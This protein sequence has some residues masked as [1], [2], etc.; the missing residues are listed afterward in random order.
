M[1][2]VID[3]REHRICSYMKDKLIEH[4]VE[5][6]PLGDMV[7]KNDEGE[8]LVLFERKSIQDLLSSVAD[9]RYDEQSFRLQEC[10]LD[11]HR[12]Y[13][14]IEGNIDKY[15]GKGSGLYSKGTIHSCLFSLS[16][17]KGFSVI[18]SN[19]ITHTSDILIKFFQ[20]MQLETNHVSLNKP[21]YI[22]AIKLTKKGNVSDDMV[23]IMMLAQIPK[24]SKNV[25]ETIMKAYDYNISQ[26]IKALEVDET[27]LDDMTCN[28]ANNKVRKL[29]KPCITNVKKYLLTIRDAKV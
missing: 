10:G 23:G 25:A 1:K 19:S 8:M 15:V 21:N 5:A 16:Y 7:I 29:S 20:K 13:Y 27:C 12:I 11:K 2:L 17:M 18:C 24:V 6:L 9:G 3:C 22:D 26:V 4:T 14:I 28:I